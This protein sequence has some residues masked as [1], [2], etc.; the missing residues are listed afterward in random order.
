MDNLRYL[1]IALGMVLAL[2]ISPSS[3]TDAH[4]SDKGLYRVSWQ[5]LAPEV[6]TD[7]IHEWLLH[8]ETAD[9][10]PADNL[11]ITVSAHMPGH[12]HGLPTQPRATA[13]L[14]NG[15]YRIAGMKFQMS[16]VWWV[17]FDFWRKNRRD[18]VIF[19]VPVK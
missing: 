18:W 5:S 3:A 14:G 19:E 10:R 4:I 8:V 15:D 2:S 12:A 9:R 6:T 7:L 13:Y 16:G 17:R 1:R 11:I